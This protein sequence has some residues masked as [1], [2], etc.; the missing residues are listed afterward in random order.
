MISLVHIGK[1]G[2][3]TIKQLLKPKLKSFKEYHHVKN[4]S[5]NE[6]YIIWIRNPIS[7]FVSAFNHAYYG[8]TANL[9]GS[10]GLNF[11]NCLI[12]D[13][14]IKARKTP[15]IFSKK[16]DALMLRFNSPNDLAESLSS[17]DTEKRNTAIELMK[18]TEE[19][20]FKGIGWYL[21]KGKF[22]KNRHS[23]ILF[24]GRQENM[25]EDIISLGKLLNLTLDENKK[26]RENTYLD[27]SMKYLSPFAI[28]NIIEWYKPTDYRALLVLKNHG[29]ISQETLE[30]YYSYTH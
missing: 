11:E 27:S 21:N 5:D 24:V 16:Y 14:M 4:Y 30:S 2:G 18:C 6:K 7:R 28:K 22:V 1:T 8:L 23:K 12:P 26:V 29:F 3:T 19:H 13:R 9:S 25:K 20:L 10:K 15:Y 17:T